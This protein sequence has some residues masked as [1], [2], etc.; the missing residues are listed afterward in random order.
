MGVKVTAN[1]YRNFWRRNNKENSARRNS[2]DHLII[3]SQVSPVDQVS[4]Q[5]EGLR[6]AE[7]AKQILTLQ[8]VNISLSVAARIVS[9]NEAIVFT[10]RFHDIIKKDRK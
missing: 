3:I 1:V 2:W 10:M 9:Q 4:R 8:T 5:N 7:R 6:V